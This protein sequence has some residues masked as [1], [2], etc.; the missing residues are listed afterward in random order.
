MT[1]SLRPVICT[2]ARIR[3]RQFTVD[4]SLPRIERLY[5]ATLARKTRG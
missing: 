1:S 5:E 3:S 4:V 2:A